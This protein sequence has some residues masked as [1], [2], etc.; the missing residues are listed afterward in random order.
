MD[1][2]SRQ[3]ESSVNE[4]DATLHQSIAAYQLPK[5]GECFD[6]EISY[7]NVGRRLMKRKEPT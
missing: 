4:P 1:A 2:P 7:K 5:K 6:L 3:A